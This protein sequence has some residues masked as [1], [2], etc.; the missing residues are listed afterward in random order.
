MTTRKKPRTKKSRPG[1]KM[2]GGLWPEWFWKRITP[3]SSSANC[4]QTQDQ[5]Y[6]EQQYQEQQ[7]QPQEQQYQP[8][9]QQYQGQGGKKR[10]SKR[11][12][13]KTYRA[14][15]KSTRGRSIKRK[16]SMA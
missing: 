13:R 3:S 16:R 10:R 14:G 2:T 8:Q 15:R 7:Y 9:E 5:Q 4:P 1:R 6:Q 12:L 11:S